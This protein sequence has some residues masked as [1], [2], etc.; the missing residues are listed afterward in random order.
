MK[1]SKRL[2]NDVQFFFNIS[3]QEFT[4][5]LP[6]ACCISCIRLHRNHSWP[7]LGGMQA[8]GMESSA[9]FRALDS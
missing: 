6:Y 5:A 2:C 4:R 1:R 7:S 9:K 3:R 8:D